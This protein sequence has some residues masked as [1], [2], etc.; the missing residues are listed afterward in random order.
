M[1]NKGTIAAAALASLLICETQGFSAKTPVETM[2]NQNMAVDNG[3]LEIGKD[4]AVVLISHGVPMGDSDGS[5]EE[6][7]I[8]ENEAST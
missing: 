6:E 8:T 7:I 4:Q 3:N 5:S 1:R 2:L